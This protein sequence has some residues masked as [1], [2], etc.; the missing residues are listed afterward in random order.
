VRREAIE[1]LMTLQEE[2]VSEDTRQTWNNWRRAHPD[3]EL[4]WTT[5]E[6]F[7]AR[8]RG[9][10]SPLA[11]ATLASSS[12]I[13]RRQVLKGMA[14]LLLAGGTAWTLKS[15]PA[16][17]AWNADKRTGFNDRASIELADGTRVELNT[18][19]AIDIR[20]S[21]K[22]HLI[23]LIE[24]EILISPPKGSRAE[25]NSHTRPLIV[26]TGQGRILAQ[27]ARFSVRDF[28]S[29]GRSVS[30]VSVFEGTCE[31]Q[32]AQT[33]APGKPL[34]AGQQALFN[35]DRM[36]T[37]GRAVETSTAWSRGMIIAQDMP[38]AT[39]LEELGRYR[40]GRLACD[41]RLA[42]LKVSGT[43]PLANTDQI[44]DALASTLPLKVR[45]V[46]GY[47]VVLKPA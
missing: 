29:E 13:D 32:P 47:W 20:F 21:S 44:L 36:E 41:P 45:R 34:L 33:R 15:E 30:R 28:S 39:F 9:L 6:A 27:D 26:Q 25:N 12:T 40:R 37:P 7:G 14:V 22:E 5:V 46:T 4:A 24:G 38:L 3:H 16:L 10:D 11:H 35:Q 19:S 23:R 31:V 43:Y 17:L 42:N 1:W 18:G 8:L 2:V